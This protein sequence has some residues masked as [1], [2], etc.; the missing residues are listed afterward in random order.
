M[1]ARDE[2]RLEAIERQIAALEAERA[3]LQRAAD[4]EVATAGER[5]PSAQRLALGSLMAILVVAT[6]AAAGAYL[7]GEPV[8]AATAGVFAGSAL[9]LSL[10]QAT[11]IEEVP[12]GHVLVLHGRA[13]AD[14]SNR[15]YRAY[16]GGRVLRRPLVERAE[17]LDCRARS[18]DVTVQGAYSRGNRPLDVTLRGRVK[19]ATFEPGVVHAIER[20]LGVD[21]REVGV[22][23]AQT[24]EGIVRER[25]AERTLEELGRDSARFVEE[26]IEAAEPDLERLG[27]SL[28]TL[29]LERLVASG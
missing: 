11:L 15:G 4:D 14:G 22:V 19:L 26:V 16:A 2:P 12:A 3:S 7:L 23:A 8:I 13:A 1:P 5:A 20:F 29:T 10:V 18:I 24:L 28:E 17:R 21:P 6:I 27:V 9:V 25:L